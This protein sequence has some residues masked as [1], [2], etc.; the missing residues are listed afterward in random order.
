MKAILNKIAKIG[1]PIR[2]SKQKPVGV[3]ENSAEAAF[4]GKI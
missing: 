1:I 3:N 2:R 4:G